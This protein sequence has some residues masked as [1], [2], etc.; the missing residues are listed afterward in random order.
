[1]TREISIEAEVPGTPEQVWN[2]IATGPGI[3]GW[4]VSTE[5][6]ESTMTQYHGNGFD[7]TSDIVAFEPPRRFAYTDEFQ[8]S[9]DSEPSVVATEFLV[10][11]R[12]GGTCVVRVVQSGFGAGDAW[13]RA[14]EGFRGGWRGALDDLRLY[15]THFA[16]EPVAGFATGRLLELPRER[17]W[18]AL[19]EALGLPDAI[20]PGDRVETRGAP[21]YAGTVVR[22]DEASVSLLLDAPGRGLGYLGTGG[23]TNEVFAFVRARVFG[24]DAAAT[25]EREGAAWEEWLSSAAAWNPNICPGAT[26]NDT[27]SSATRS[28]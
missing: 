11:A 17:A 4:F 13:R 7:Q 22:A 12:S 9:P 5:I 26:E 8:P 10:E 28:P 23:P 15:L 2:A 20:A 1:M 24:D 19:R 21:P 25:A 14:S 6:A 27:P 16:G 3:S 18:P